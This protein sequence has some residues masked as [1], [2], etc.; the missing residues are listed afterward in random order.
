MHTGDL[1]ETGHSSFEEVEKHAIIWNKFE[2]EGCIIEQSKKSRIYL[3]VRE[4]LKRKI[5]Q[6]NQPEMLLMKYKKKKGD[7]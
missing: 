7:N 4:Q 6:G 5:E 2:Y 3:S 1:S